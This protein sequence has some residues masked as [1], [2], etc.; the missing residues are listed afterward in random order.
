MRRWFHRQTGYWM[1]WMGDRYVYEHRFVI[2]QSLGRKLQRGEIVH[3]INENKKDNRLENL[4]L[5]TL[6]EHNRKH[7]KF[8]G[9]N[10]P[11]TNMTDKH[12]DSLRLAWIKRKEKFGNEGSRNP[13]LL[14]QKGR[15]NAYK[16]YGGG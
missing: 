12:K 10:N 11:S 15:E 13:E 6:A 8:M 1:L 9:D 5:M 3:H 14:R 2:E 16:R 7:N 4:E